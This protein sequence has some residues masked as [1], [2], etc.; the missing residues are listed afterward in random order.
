MEGLSDEELGLLVGFSQIC[1]PPFPVCT[2]SLVSHVHRDDHAAFSQ[3]F[4]VSKS[5]YIEN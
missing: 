4:D 1:F 5:T 2:F 3:P